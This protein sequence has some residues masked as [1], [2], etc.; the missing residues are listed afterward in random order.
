MDDA[1]RM[2][3][4]DK[5]EGTELSDRERAESLE[6]MILESQDKFLS[7]KAVMEDILTDVEEFF[8]EIEGY[9]DFALTSLNDFSNPSKATI[10]LNLANALIGMVLRYLD[11]NQP[12][13]VVDRMLKKMKPE[14]MFLE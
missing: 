12:T 5:E 8:G 7:F 10:Y 9:V 13:E 14:G 1:Q 3:Y 2:R 11:E 4:L 6:K